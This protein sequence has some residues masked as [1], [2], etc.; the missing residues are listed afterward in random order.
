MLSALDNQILLRISC[1]IRISFDWEGRCVK[2]QVTRVARIE[3]EEFNYKI[4]G[5]KTMGGAGKELK[6]CQTSSDHHHRF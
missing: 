2:G 3:L 1:S 6:P 4:N 5:G